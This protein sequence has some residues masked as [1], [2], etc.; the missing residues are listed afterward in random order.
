MSDVNSII[1]KVYLI[2]QPSV[3]RNGQSPDLT[4]LGEHGEITVL[5]EAGIYPSHNADR[6]TNLINTRLSNFDYNYDMIAWA[7]G[8]TI[9]AI[10]VGIA[11]ADLQIPW[12]WYLRY[13]RKR[14]KETGKRLD[15][16]YYKKVKIYTDDMTIPANQTTLNL[17]EYGDEE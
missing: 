3:K 10:I 13:E 9:A 11:L 16:G 12:F 6:A 15:K 4:P 14:C 5:I 2:A 8:D 1:G 7:G 17:N